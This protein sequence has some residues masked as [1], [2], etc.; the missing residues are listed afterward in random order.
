MGLVLDSHIVIGACAAVSGVVAGVV[1]GWIARGRRE[2]SV[3][4]ELTKVRALL[5]A[6]FVEDFDKAKTIRTPPRIAKV[7][8][9]S[10]RT[11][12]LGELNDYARRSRAEG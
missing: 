4:T 10:T 1:A 7:E 9:A 8:R 2:Q 12:S 5:E 3:W 6:R 11:M